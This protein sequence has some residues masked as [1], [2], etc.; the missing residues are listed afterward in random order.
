MIPI[1]LIS[2]YDIILHFSDLEVNASHASTNVFNQLIMISFNLDCAI[3]L[4]TQ[5]W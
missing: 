3:G 5:D 4:V 2:W 1:K